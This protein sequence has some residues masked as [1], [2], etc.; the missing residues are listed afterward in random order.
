MDTPKYMTVAELSRLYVLGRHIT[1]LKADSQHSDTTTTT[2]LGKSN[3]LHI[4]EICYTSNEK[5]QLPCGHSICEECEKRWVSRKLTCPFCRMRFGS[6]KKAAVNG[7]NLTE[8]D[9]ELLQ[10]DVQLLQE[11]LNTAW[12]TAILPKSISRGN[13][14]KRACVALPPRLL[15]RRETQDFVLIDAK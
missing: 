9:P 14:T 1:E 13:I 15:E 6:A 10:R 11:E 8:F 3:D 4:C 5:T 7:W 2:S 12:N